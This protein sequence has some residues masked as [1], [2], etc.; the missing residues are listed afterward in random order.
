MRDPKATRLNAMIYSRLMAAALLLLMAFF[1]AGTAAGASTPVRIGVLA[2]KG[3]D[4]CRD[5]WE[6]T[7]DYLE[8]A[9]PG[10]R[11]DLAPLNFEEI[12]PAVRD[13]SIDFLICNP[14]I[15]VDLEVRFGITRTMTLRN[16]AGTRIVSEF[17]GVIFCRADRDDLNNLRD[18][19]GRRLAAVRETSFGGWHMALRE[20]RSA[21]IDPAQDCARLFFLGSHPAVVRA[22][23]SGEAEI[24]IVRTDTLE[25]MAADGE[26]RLDAIRVITADA[27]PGSQSTFPYLH[28][29]RLYPEWP[30]AKLSGTTEEL[31][32][33]V[34]VALLSMPAD[35]PAAIAAQ[36]GGWGVCL[37]YT[38]VHDCLR[39]LRLPP[40][41]HYG[42]MS[43]LDIWRQYWPWLGAIGALIISLLGALLLLRGRQLAVL[44]VSGQN[45]LL[46]ASAGE[47]ICGIDI[48]GI[49]TFVNPAASKI[50]GFTAGELIG[51]DLH[52]LTHHTKSDGQPYPDHECPINKACNDGT[53]YRG[54]DAFFYRKDGRAIPVSYSS[55]PIVDMGRIRGAVICFQDITVQKRIKEE[56][57]HINETLEQRVAQTVEKTMEQERMLTRQNRLAAM[58][59]MIANIAHQWRQPL[60]ALGLLL[61]NIKDAF[62]F[63]TLDAAF[64]DQAIADGNRLV[65]KMSATIS[66][67]SNFFRPDKEIVAFS[68]R[69]QIEEAIALVE[70]SFQNSKISIH[71]DAPRDLKLLGFPNEYSQVLLNLLSNAKEAI[72]DRKPPHQSGSGRVDILLTERCGQ[73]C[74]SVSDNGGGIP[75]DSLDRIFDPYFSTKESGTGIGLYMSKMI[76]ERNMNGSITA[77]NIEGGAEFSV[78]APLA[79]DGRHGPA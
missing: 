50:L 5:M 38:S 32:R 48:K 37:D 11:F 74:V 22:V 76:I 53:V 64:L 68:A 70:S 26:I 19:R 62:H 2:H 23:L 36:S 45:R 29:T 47:G 33:E 3:T 46:L 1:A 60:N 17:G 41:E 61:F 42:Q 54:S 8:M 79:A 66:D 59:E 27:A 28:S 18:V 20:F 75:A 52:E 77:K 9:L 13:K 67:F 24:G 51:R 44:R 40:Y 65:Q 34:T 31:S 58:G 39:E 21:G 4:I 55:R 49:T 15:Y 71:V 72:L 7:M 14:A 6:P 73:G 56:L 35:S 69:G 16:R 10:R 30:F 57:L 78:Y 12:E 63:D 43:S 25:R